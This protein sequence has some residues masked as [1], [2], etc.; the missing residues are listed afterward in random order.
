V[1]SEQ[2]G[3]S[4]QR[5]FVKKK[6]DLPEPLLEPLKFLHTL[7]DLVRKPKRVFSKVGQ[8]EDDQYV[9][10]WAFVGYTL[11]AFDV[12]FHSY[13]YHI[14]NPQY[15]RLAVIWPS[16]NWFFT[17]LF[18]F[19]GI[20][21][22]FVC[23]LLLVALVHLLLLLRWCKQVLQLTSLKLLGYSIAAAMWFLFSGAICYLF[24]YDMGGGG[25]VRLFPWLVVVIGVWVL[26]NSSWEAASAVCPTADKLSLRNR[27]WGA[28][29]VSL[30]LVALIWVLPI[31]ERF[32]LLRNPVREFAML[33]EE[34]KAMQ[35]MAAFNVLQAF[36][37]N[38]NNR[39][40]TVEEL[41][42]A[43]W[44][45]DF[46]VSPEE[47]A[48]FHKYLESPGYMFAVTE[49][50]DVCYLAAFPR[51]Y[52]RTG[53]NSFFVSTLRFGKI[54]A[55]DP[56]QQQT[57]ANVRSASQWPEI[58]SEC[59]AFL[60]VSKPFRKTVSVRLSN[61]DMSIKDRGE[62]CAELTGRADLLS[63]RLQFVRKLAAGRLSVARRKPRPPNE[64]L[65]QIGILT[66]EICENVSLARVQMFD[67]VSLSK[68]AE[69]AGYDRLFLSL[70]LGRSWIEYD[71]TLRDPIV[72]S[73]KC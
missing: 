69:T 39:C 26:G 44:E 43:L 27:S 21:V 8:G 70:L 50:P 48:P 24:L 18:A 3:L 1:I 12:L 23:V 36:N 47:A 4:K 49:W 73:F 53:R 33:Q 14:G 41:K 7:L 17:L 19:T 31:P 45:I 54:R 68:S 59:E 46:I 38:R 65:K 51:R 29:F 64:D 16:E 60:V 57:Q 5:E 9:S 63:T 11:V 28:T 40:S 56:G 2:E 15:A 13:S 32:T 66:E 42:E 71:M 6:H 35:T 58:T 37:L 62:L 34:Y 52:G 55:Q 67:I 22:S 72:L 25:S 61:G 20:S 10:P 30:F